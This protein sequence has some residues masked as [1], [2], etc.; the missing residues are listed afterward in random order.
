MDFLQINH[1]TKEEF[2]KIAETLFNEYAIQTYD[3]IYRIIELEVYW[4]SPKHIDKS[5]YTRTHVDPK[6]GDWFFHYSGVDI[7]LKNETSGGYGG[8]LLRSIIDLKNK[9]KLY[10]GPMVCSMR[11]FSGTNAFE[12]TIRTRL[13]PH[14]FEKLQTNTGPRIGLG[15]NALENDA[16]KL[17]YRF[18]I[19]PI[20]EA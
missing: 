17:Q 2:Q 8:I 7:A 14:Y 20:Y 12:D 19:N 6:A 11:L 1:E 4:N 15:K 13:V 18:Y 10:K 3:S 9:N 5:T 16:N